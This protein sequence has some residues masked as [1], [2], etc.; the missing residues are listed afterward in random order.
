MGV[1]AQEVPLS[2]ILPTVR[3]TLRAHREIRLTMFL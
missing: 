1:T 2:E 3:R